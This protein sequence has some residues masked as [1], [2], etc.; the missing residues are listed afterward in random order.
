MRI[1]ALRT[2]GHTSPSGRKESHRVSGKDPLKVKVSDSKLV[3]ASHSD[4][5]DLSASVGPGRG[6]AASCPHTIPFGGVPALPFS[7]LGVLSGGLG[8][9]FLLLPVVEWLGSFMH[10]CCGGGCDIVPSPSHCP[11]PCSCVLRLSARLQVCRS[12]HLT[13]NKHLLET[14]WLHHRERPGVTQEELIK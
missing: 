10:S 11:V 4:S 13:A 12:L 1:K 14:V 8:T 7:G 2:S 5:S 3:R 6:Q 9:A